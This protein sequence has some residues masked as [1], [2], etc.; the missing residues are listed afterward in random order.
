MPWPDP[1]T[2]CALPRPFPLPQ[3]VQRGWDSGAGGEQFTVPQFASTTAGGIPLFQTSGGGQQAA[4]AAGDGAASGAL[5]EGSGASGPDQQQQQQTDAQAGGMP[6][7]GGLQPPGHLGGAAAE[8][9]GDGS[10]PL[11]AAHAAVPAGGAAAGGVHADCGLHGDP[12]G[13]ALGDH[14]GPA[15]LLRVGSGAGCCLVLAA[16]VFLVGVALLGLL[17]SAAAAAASAATPASG[18]CRSNGETLQRLPPSIPCTCHP[19]VCSAL[20]W[21][22]RP[23]LAQRAAGGGWSCAPRPAARTAPQLQVRPPGTDVWCC[24][25]P[26]CGV[27]MAVGGWVLE[28]VARTPVLPLLFMQLHAPPT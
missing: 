12:L 21:S 8:G 28:R 6:P 4:A 10:G 20:P 14:Q 23:R 24:R 19:P 7:P 2:A 25:G 15:Q 26:G 11:H 9:M 13:A 22:C 18:L 17:W 16:A 1:C 5:L 3:K 27:C